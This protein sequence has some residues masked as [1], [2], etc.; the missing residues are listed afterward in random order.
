MH[1]AY[2]EYGY[3]LKEIARYLGVYDTNA[4]DL[5]LDIRLYM[6]VD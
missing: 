6:I 4:N 1:Q 2:Q 5:L 3:T